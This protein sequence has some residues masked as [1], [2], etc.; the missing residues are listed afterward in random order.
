MP[1]KDADG[2]L[3]T[4][5]DLDWSAVSVIWIYTVFYTC[6][7]KRLRKSYSIFKATVYSYH[8]KY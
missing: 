4:S 6:L 2:L 3:Q 5:V 7:L 8:L 1:L